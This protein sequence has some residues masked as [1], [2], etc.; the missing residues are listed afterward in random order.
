MTILR[1]IKNSIKLINTSHKCLKKCFL[2]YPC[3]S[4]NQAVPGIEKS[5]L[6]NIK[7]N[8]EHHTQTLSHIHT[9]YL[10]HMYVFYAHVFMTSYSF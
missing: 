5:L 1:N 2:K 9:N 3:D 8:N 4:V 6:T 10:V 7:C